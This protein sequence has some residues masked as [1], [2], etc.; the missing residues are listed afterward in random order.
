MTHPPT[1]PSNRRTR[2]RRRIV[3][4]VAGLL[5]L[6]LGAAAGALWLLTVKLLHPIDD[7]PLNTRILAVG[8]ETVTLPATAESRYTGTYGLVWQDSGSAQHSGVL[9]RI[10]ASD[11]TTVTRE[12]QATTPPAVGDKAKIT[13]T[14]WDTDPKQALGLDYQDVTYPSD[15]GP[16]PAWYLPGT[17]STWV[18]QVHGL[19]AGRSAGLRTVPELHDLGYPVLDITYR[20]DPGAPHDSNGNRQ[21][22]N[23]EWHDL[24]TAVRYARAHGAAG[25]VLYGFSMGGGI[26]ENYL[27]RATD[28]SAVRSVVLDAPALDYGAAINTIATNLGIPFPVA[29]FATPFIRLRAGVDLDQ[30]DTLAANRRS[31]GPKQPVLLFHGTADTIVPYATSARFARDWPDTIHLVTVPGAGHTGAWNADPARY[32]SELAN[33]LNQQT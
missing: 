32:E 21:L 12:L 18:I 33:F 23:T 20:N 8:T 26:V 9:S 13:V 10:T 17:R 3:I 15:L 7:T 25:V 4:I 19:G 5:V 11:A 22:G 6:T 27:Q 31:G 28:T 29:D 16:M 2:L 1:P 14:V 24:D 30:V